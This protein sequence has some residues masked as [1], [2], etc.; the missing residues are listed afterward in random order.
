MR[1]GQY[2]CCSYYSHLFHSL[3]SPGNRGKSIRGEARESEYQDS[4]QME[5]PAMGES[6]PLLSRT[7]LMSGPLPD[8]EDMVRLP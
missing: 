6:A 1:D 2:F 5:W 8:L 3:K 4:G 7:S